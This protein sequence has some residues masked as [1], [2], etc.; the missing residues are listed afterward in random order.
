MPSSDRDAIP[1]AAE[2]ECRAERKRTG[3]IAA[4][5]ASDPNTVRFHH[6][7]PSERAAIHFSTR[8]VEQD[9]NQGSMPLDL[10]TGIAVGPV[11]NL[12]KAIGADR[13]CK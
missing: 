3:P 2:I 10:I 4:E 6:E 1:S 9:Q 11:R 7:L 13:P 8:Y 12:I 5:I